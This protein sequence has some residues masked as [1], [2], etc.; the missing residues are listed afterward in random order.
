MEDIEGRAL[1]TFSSPVKCWKRYVDDVLCVVAR[2]DIE[3]LLQHINNIEPSIQF[4]FESQSE[5]GCLPFL[6]V[7]LRRDED[8]SI[9]TSVYRKPT[10]TDKYLDFSSHHPIAH[11]ASVVK[12]LFS[13]ADT[14]SSSPT[15]IS[16]EQERIYRALTTNHYPRSFINR[17][18]RKKPSILP[19]NRDRF[20]RTI[21]IPYIRGVSEAVKRAL[22]PAKVRVVF[23]PNTTLRR[24]LVKVKDHTPEEKKA[25]VVY[26]IPCTTCPAEY[27]GQT[28]RLLE[29]RLSEHKA[30]VK[31]AKCDVSAVADH[32]WNHHHQM[33]FS[34]TSVLAQ[35]NNQHQRCLLESWFIR[36]RTT[37]NRE[38]GSLL[39]MYSCLF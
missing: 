13:R 2:H 38:V 19:S 3:S 37:I 18:I 32:V 14:L 23:Q 35:E 27:I 9:S 33:D 39:P 1:D 7:M 36:T 29:T 15:N 5:E 21:T 25:N 17:V 6:D 34:N 30:A 10:H 20:V 8:G 11:K 16:D 31:H 28:G 24:L 26:S 4:T 22:E 12:T